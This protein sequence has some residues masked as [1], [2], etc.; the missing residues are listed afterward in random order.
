MDEPQKHYPYVQSQK[1]DTR[2]HIVHDSTYMKCS[3][4]ALET[5]SRLVVDGGGGSGENTS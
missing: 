4:E 1:L 5:K 3:K 2:D